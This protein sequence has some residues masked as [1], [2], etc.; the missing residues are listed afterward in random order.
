MRQKKR[1]WEF[2]WK[3]LLERK[4]MCIELVW[5]F[6]IHIIWSISLVLTYTWNWG[7]QRVSNSSLTYT[8]PGL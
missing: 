2:Q 3:D 1:V 5:K 4:E 8:F 7:Y 6:E